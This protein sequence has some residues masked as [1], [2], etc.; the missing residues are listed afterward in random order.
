MREVSRRRRH[1]VPTLLEARARK[2]D[3]K[4]RVVRKGSAVDAWHLADT[5]RC[6]RVV[7][8]GEMLRLTFAGENAEEP[9]TP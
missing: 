4:W 3:R 5:A 7:R 9:Q 6:M 1:C 8:A 2:R